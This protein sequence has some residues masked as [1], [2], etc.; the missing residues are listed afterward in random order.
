MTIS[1]GLFIAIS[2]NALLCIALLVLWFLSRVQLAALRRRLDVL[3][4][5]ADLSADNFPTIASSGKKR[6]ITVELLNPM[7]LAAKESWFARQFGTLTPAL[8]HK[9]VY[10]QARDRVEQQMPNF[11]ATAEVKV[12]VI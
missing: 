10:A 5:D 4:I 6:L 3:G 11:G 8:V 9:L 7:Q 12:H 1:T 2:I